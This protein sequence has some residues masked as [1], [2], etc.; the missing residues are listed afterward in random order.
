MATDFQGAYGLML[1][2]LGTKSPWLMPAPRASARLTIR[3]ERWR[4]EPLPDVT[5]ERFTLQIS[6]LRRVRVER[7]PATLIV[8]SAT[9]VPDHLVV[10]PYLS[11]AAA[12]CAQWDGSLALHAGVVAIDG[13][14]WVLLADTSCGKTSL[15]AAFAQRGYTVLADDLAIIDPD[16]MVRSGPRCLDLRTDA[17]R[18]LRP[19]GHVASIRGRS[20]LTL[21]PAPPGLPIGGF[22]ALRWGG[23]SALDRLGLAER[24]QILVDSRTAWG[25]SSATS[26]LDILDAPFLQ[27]TRPRDFSAL[28]ET[29]GVFVSGVRGQ[30]GGLQR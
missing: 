6:G 22:A 12:M 26:L 17:V 5:G 15:L 29:I 10:H 9:A 4:P 24:S 21:G 14:A 16:G 27:L 11:Y 8:E 30:P 25:P 1:D 13:W 19:S 2:G 20:R 3:H 7:D 28:D 18:A 23:A